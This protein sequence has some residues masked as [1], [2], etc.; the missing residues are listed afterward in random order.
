MPSTASAS[1]LH[2]GSSD[3]D[4]IVG[5]GIG[6][7][8]LGGADIVSGR[9]ITDLTDHDGHDQHDPL[10]WVPRT[11]KSPA[12]KFFFFLRCSEKN[13][14][15][16]ARLGPRLRRPPNLINWFRNDMWELHEFGRLGAPK[17]WG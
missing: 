4:E 17:S 10:K 7:A 3:D 6:L 1:D 8:C 2:S 14:K 11:P 5:L 15:T 12:L 13:K 16:P 9:F